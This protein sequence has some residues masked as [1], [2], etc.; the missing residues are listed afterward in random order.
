MSMGL[1][2]NTRQ[3]AKTRG[4][5]DSES[6]DSVFA[7]EVVESALI[8]KK[9]E[10]GDHADT[11]R[12]GHGPMAEILALMDIGNVNLDGGDFARL[13][14]VAQGDAG[15]GEAGRVED[16]SAEATICI[17]CDSIDD[18]AL[19]VGLE[20]VDFN[21]RAGDLFAQLRFEIGQGCGSVDLWFP[22]AEAVEVGPVDDGYLLHALFEE[23]Y[24][25]VFN[26]KG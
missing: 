3:A 17:V 25:R 6:G 2:T 26:M 9:S 15:M 13:N 21:L 8:A 14:G 18:G 22:A 1:R 12:C 24:V 7:Q 23:W 10:S 11:D 16:D 5:V 4:Q 19:V 20:E